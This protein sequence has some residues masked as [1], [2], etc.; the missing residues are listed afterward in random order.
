MR[1]ELDIF[2]GRPNPTW[3]LSSEEVDEFTARLSDLTPCDR[4]F[5]PPGLGYRGFEIRDLG[6]RPEIPARLR[7]L[8]GFVFVFEDDQTRCFQDE[9]GIEGWLIEQARTRGYDVPSR[10]Q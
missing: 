9:K 10:S 5:A 7:V 1:V 3:E 8:D 6:E 4:A 2:S